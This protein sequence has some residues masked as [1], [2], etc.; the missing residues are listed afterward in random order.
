M[1][2]ANGVLLVVFG[3]L[4]QIL[5]NIVVESQLAMLVEEQDGRSRELLGAR[6]QLKDRLGRDGLLVLEMGPAV[7]LLKNHLAMLEDEHGCSWRV[8]LDASV[9]DDRVDAAGEVGFARVHPGGG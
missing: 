5:S 7:A 2:N 1:E 8:G 9:C 4:R 6:R 3:Q